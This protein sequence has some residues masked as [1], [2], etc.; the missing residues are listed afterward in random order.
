VGKPSW[1][2][3]HSFQNVK[4][5][6][7]LPCNAAACTGNYFRAEVYSKRGWNTWREADSNLQDLREKGMVGIAAVDSS[8][9]D[10]D[11]DDIRGAI[12]LETEMHRAS[13]PTGE[14]LGAPSWRWFRPTR[15]GQWKNLDALTDALVKGVRRVDGMGIENVIALINPRAYFLALAAAVNEC[16]LLKNWILFRMPAHPRHLI[17]AVREVIPII[18]AI[19]IREGRP[20]GGIY[21]IPK[22]FPFLQTEETAYRNK[23]PKRWGAYG[24]LP[25]LNE[26]ENKWSSIEK[27]IGRPQLMG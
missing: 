25:K 11:P 5:L 4:V 27:I 14:D 2:Q 17:P 15:S 20:T 8:T 26:I 21:H 19:T 16:D 13:N 9:L 23:L 24:K 12:V 10:T 1:I 7:L 6:F 22:L 18:R 3:L